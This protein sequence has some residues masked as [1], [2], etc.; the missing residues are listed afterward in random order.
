MKEQILSWLKEIYI[1]EVIVK[2][3]TPV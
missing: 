2:E 1:I 3:R